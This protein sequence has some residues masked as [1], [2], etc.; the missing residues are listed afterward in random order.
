GC[1]V[2][3]LYGDPAGDRAARRKRRSG[4]VLLGR[5]PGPGY[6]QYLFS[7]QR[8][9]SRGQRIKPGH[10]APAIRCRIRGTGTAGRTKRSV[11]KSAPA[12][13]NR[14]KRED[15]RHTLPA[16]AGSGTACR[17]CRGPA[18][19]RLD[20]SGTEKT[21]CSCPGRISRKEGNPAACFGSQRAG[22]P[23][24]GNRQSVG[25]CSQRG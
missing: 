1:L 12:T 8:V 9:C 25:E 22:R 2:Q 10:R 3:R 5:V 17:A 18:Q 21:D 7:A 13:G 23:A 19:E 11:E 4:P 24:G 20:R 6:S 15:Q 14:T 16:A